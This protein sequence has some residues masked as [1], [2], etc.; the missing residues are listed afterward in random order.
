MRACSFI[1]EC[2]LSYAK[3]VQTSA[4]RACSFIAE[5]SLSYAKIVQTSAMRACSFIAECSLSCA[6]IMTGECRSKNV[7]RS[8]TL[9]DTAEPHLILCKDSI[10]IIQRKI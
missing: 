1:A 7:R 6:K 2:S 3:I 4:M 8:F 5:C 10:N 9:L